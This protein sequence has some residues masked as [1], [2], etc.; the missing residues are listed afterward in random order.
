MVIVLSELPTMVAVI[1]AS[2]G[3]ENT[4][5]SFCHMFGIQGGPAVTSCTV[6]PPTTLQVPWKI[7]DPVWYTR[8]RLPKLSK[9]ARGSPHAAGRES[10]PDTPFAIVRGAQVSPPS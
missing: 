10:P 2:P 3:G 7:T 6:L 9:V 1:G 4:I 8:N 5:T